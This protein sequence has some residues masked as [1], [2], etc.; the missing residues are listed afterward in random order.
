MAYTPGTE[1]RICRSTL[2][3]P[4]SV[5]STPRS[6]S[7]MSSVF[8]WR[9]MALSTRSASMICVSPLLVF[10]DSFTPSAPISADSNLAPVST[11]IPRLR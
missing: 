4:R 3:K 11:S 2:G 8:G 1:V 7:P 9:P 10:T 6:S 5:I